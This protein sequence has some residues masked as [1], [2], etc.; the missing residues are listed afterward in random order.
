MENARDGYGIDFINHNPISEEVSL[1]SLRSPG[2]ICRSRGCRTA[3]TSGIYKRAGYML[4]DKALIYN[5]FPFVDRRLQPCS[6]LVTT[7][8]IQEPRYC[9]NSEQEVT[10]SAQIIALLLLGKNLQLAFF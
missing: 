9:C 7:D 5:N 4:T 2:A 3:G 6:L 1:I 8:E 10:K